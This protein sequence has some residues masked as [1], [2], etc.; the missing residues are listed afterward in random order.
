MVFTW[1]SPMVLPFGK[2]PMF[3]A[4]CMQQ[5]PRKRGGDFYVLQQK[6]KNEFANLKAAVVSC[7]ESAET[8]DEHYITDCGH[9]TEGGR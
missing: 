3:Q 6:D 9:N 2:T 5:I 8:R 1:A 7:P 4:I